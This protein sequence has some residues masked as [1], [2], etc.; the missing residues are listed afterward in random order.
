M[1]SNSI[2]GSTSWVAIFLG[3]LMCV[4]VMLEGSDIKNKKETWSEGPCA[5]QRR[6]LKLLNI[7]RYLSNI[8]PM[9]LETYLW[10]HAIC[11]SKSISHVYKIIH[12]NDT[13]NGINK[14]PLCLPYLFNL[15]IPKAFILFN[16]AT[17]ILIWKDMMIF[18][19]PALAL[20]NCSRVTLSLP[21]WFC[22]FQGHQIRNARASSAL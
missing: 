16:L 11:W 6:Y 2:N 4:S 1:S 18:L 3:I 20:T 13:W 14:F 17:W 8:L 15:E 7:K 12:L 21:C 9:G 22:D 5:T 19:L 10:K